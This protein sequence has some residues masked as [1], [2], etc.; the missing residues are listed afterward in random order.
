M[1]VRVLHRIRSIYSP[2]LF[3]R[4]P[5]KIKPLEQRYTVVQGTDFELICDT[6]GSPYPTVTWS[7]VSFS[8]LFLILCNIIQFTER[9]TTWSQRKTNRKYIENL[10]HQC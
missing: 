8:F 2:N 10:K 9:R 5:A 1:L 4:Q 6:T 7:M 3:H